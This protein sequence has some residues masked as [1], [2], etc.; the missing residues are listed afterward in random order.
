M[1]ASSAYV[2]LLV[3]ISCTLVPLGAT[4]SLTRTSDNVV[5]D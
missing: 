2:G 5:I 1:W 4:S 3:E